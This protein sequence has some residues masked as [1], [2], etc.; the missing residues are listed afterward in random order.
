[1]DE[2]HHGG[3]AYP[4]FVKK[5]GAPIQ[6]IVFVT[7]DIETPRELWKADPALMVHCQTLHDTIMRT[8]ITDHNGYEVSA[9]GDN[10]CIAFHNAED[11][12]NFGFSI[13]AQLLQTT[14][15][16]ELLENPKCAIVY[17]S[18][19]SAK[20]TAAQSP[21]K[22]SKSGSS[23]KKK[24]KKKKKRSQS[25]AQQ[26]MAQNTVGSSAF[27]KKNSRPLFNGLRVRM[28]MDHGYC[29]YTVNNMTDKYSYT[30]GPVNHC[31]AILKAMQSG[32][33]IV[34]TKSMNKA[35]LEGDD[36]FQDSHKVSLG[37]HILKD[38]EEPMEL[39]QCLPQELAEREL[40]PLITVRK[41]GPDFYD[42]PSANVPDGM[43]VP[44]VT[45]VSS[46][47]ADSVMKKVRAGMA[48][49][50]LHLHDIVLRKFLQENE[51]YECQ[52]SNGKFVFAFPSPNKACAWAISTSLSFLK[53]DWSREPKQVADAMLNMKVNMGI[54]SDLCDDVEP[55]CN[56]G[57][58]D[59]FGK[60]VDVAMKCCESSASGEVSLSERAYMML[61]PKHPFG[62]IVGPAVKL[63][64]GSETIQMY[65]LTVPTSATVD[66]EHYKYTKWKPF[67]TV[68][69]A[70][71]REAMKKAAKDESREKK[72]KNKS[73]PNEVVPVE[74]KAASP[75]DIFSTS[76][77]DAWKLNDT[78]LDFDDGFFVAAGR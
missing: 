64:R 54:S 28:A 67:T 32:D 11:A 3:S 7:T 55:N 37:T 56:T 34:L 31:R 42:A 68:S 72:G 24:K 29:D 65:A 8:C 45:L 41:I 1:M 26:S 39:I 48:E 10:F 14:W 50:V 76:Q 61:P 75:L 5:R 60:V 35:L 12:I 2:A 47:I 53:L 20:S 70:E 6:D 78:E 74:K 19:N 44:P 33:Q 58:A 23:K 40:L 52:G 46:K 51:G 77:L 66:P 22:L 59:Y 69:E 16:A 13:N 62:I 30:G 43:P 17:V 27:N 18:D 15:P 9:E 73:Q 57:K 36:P 4:D 25:M 49:R 63:G 21:A 38:V 71:E